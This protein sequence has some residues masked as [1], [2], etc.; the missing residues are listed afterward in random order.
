[1]AIS[2]DEGGILI[3]LRG[4]INGWRGDSKSTT[5]LYQWME[6]DSKSTTGLYQ[7]MEGGF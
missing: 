7:W 1:M 6:G 3:V 2:V 4:Y 5:G